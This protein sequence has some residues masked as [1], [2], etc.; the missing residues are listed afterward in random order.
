[1]LC[2]AATRAATGRKNRRGC[3]AARRGSARRG[4]CLH[5]VYYI[6]KESTPEGV[7]SIH[8]HAPSTDSQKLTDL[9]VDLAVPGH[10]HGHHHQFGAALAHLVGWMDGWM[11]EISTDQRPGINRHDNPTSPSSR[12]AV[13]RTDLLHHRL[14]PVLE[15]RKLPLAHFPDPVSL[16]YALC[17][18]CCCVPNQRM[19]DGR[20]PIHVGA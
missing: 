20:S 13:A 7:K 5:M 14:R 11:H 12:P 4:R 1:M 16:P 10:V 15:P 17:P 2:P 9:V 19:R 6:S 8:V 18:R 3:C